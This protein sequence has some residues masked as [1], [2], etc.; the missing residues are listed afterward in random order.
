L[1]VSVEFYIAASASPAVAK[2]ATQTNYQ[3]LK[4]QF[5]ANAISL[6]LYIPKEDALKL[7]SQDATHLLITGSIDIVSE[8][9]CEWRLECQG[10][11]LVGL[12]GGRVCP[13]PCP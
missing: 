2:P 5:M 12:T 1:I 7:L 13:Q 10:Y 6:E 11:P 9:N 4:I 8:T 3:L